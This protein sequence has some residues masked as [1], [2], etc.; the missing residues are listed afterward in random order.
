MKKFF[1]TLIILVGLVVSWW[2]LSRLVLKFIVGDKPVACTEGAKLC[3][4]GTYVSRVGPKC[5][6]EAC[7]KEDLIQVESPRANDL[8]SNPL[9]VKGKARGFWFFE[10]VF[11]MKLLDENGKILAQ[12]HAL[13]LDDWTT[14]EFVPFEARIDFP[15]PVT[16]RGFLVLEKS[17]PSGLPE[18][19]DELRMPIFFSQ[20]SPQTRNVKLY[21]YQPEKDKDANGSVK[22]SQDGIVPVEREISVSKTP[23]QETVK[24]LLKGKENLT[25]EEINRGITTEYPLD[26]FSLK[27]ASLRNGIL[28][29]EFNDSQNKTVG[30]ACRVRILWLQIEATA[31][32]FPEVREVR[33]LPE[34]IFQP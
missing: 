4:D 11:P 31:K 34:W 12:T 19:A 21:Y 7:P 2:G 17:N 18:Y 26:G 3:S 16:Q 6:F 32:Q 13:A 33:F 25:Q 24:L 14:K 27:S 9:I 28:T 15:V 20:F 23:I 8:V 22:C 1:I 10:S 29:L 5:E 30:G